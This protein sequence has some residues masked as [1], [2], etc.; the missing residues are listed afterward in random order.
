MFLHYSQI[1]N[2]HQA[3]RNDNTSDDRKTNRRPE[4]FPLLLVVAGGHKKKLADSPC[5]EAERD[6]N[7]NEKIVHETPFEEETVELQKAMS[8]ATQRSK[9]FLQR[10]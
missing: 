9:A 5:V 1:D 10:D 6:R 3:R 7:A 2:N 8:S 4:L